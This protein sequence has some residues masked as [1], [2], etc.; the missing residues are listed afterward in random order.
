[1]ESGKLARC[2]EVCL[3]MRCK[4]YLRAALALALLSMPKLGAPFGIVRSMDCDLLVTASS[5]QQFLYPLHEAASQ[6]ILA[7]ADV[8]GHT[9]S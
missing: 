7:A 9:F 2:P 6:T 3:V 5:G 8:A 1:M 4:A